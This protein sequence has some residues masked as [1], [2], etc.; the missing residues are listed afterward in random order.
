M[1]GVERVASDAQNLT[2]AFDGKDDK[3]RFLSFS[4][5]FYGTLRDMCGAHVKR[6]CFAGSW[7]Q[8][9]CL[10]SPKSRFIFAQSKGAD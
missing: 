1:C 2:I 3:K 5:H 7:P 10:S 8:H 9:D 6:E 4:H